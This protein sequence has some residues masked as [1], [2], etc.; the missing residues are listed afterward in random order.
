MQLCLQKTEITCKN[1]ST[2]IFECVVIKMCVL[3][4]KFTASYYITAR[5][6]QREFFGRLYSWWRCSI[7]IFHKSTP[8]FSPQGIYPMV[9]SLVFRSKDKLVIRQ[10][11]DQ[12]MTDA[13]VIKHPMDLKVRL[14]LRTAPQLLRL[15]LRSSSL[16]TTCL[17]MARLPIDVKF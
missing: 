14:R 10:S 15:R 5:T 16:E 9:G 12:L 13:Y 7:L 3:P 1:Y 17:H 2:F 11:T 4:F 6:N 8:S